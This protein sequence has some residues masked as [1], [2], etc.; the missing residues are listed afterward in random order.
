MS[1][2]AVS[3][4]FYQ[5]SHASFL[6]E[7]S[8]VPPPQHEAYTEDRLGEVYIKFKNADL[9]NTNLHD[10]VFSPRPKEAW[11][12]CPLVGWCAGWCW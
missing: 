12:W 7:V 5:V 6:G 9:T 4:V 8:A 10:A 11:C 2:A 1:Y 3:G